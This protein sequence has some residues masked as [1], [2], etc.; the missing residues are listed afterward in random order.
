MAVD[1]EKTPVPEPEL[2]QDFAD[3][4]ELSLPAADE[5]RRRNRILNRL[6]VLLPAILLIG[7]IVGWR[8]MLA[9]PD[10]V[11]IGIDALT[12]I[13]FLLDV[14]LRVDTSL[15]SYLGLQV[16]PS[17]VGALIFALVTVT[18]LGY[19]KAEK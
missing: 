9:S 16:L 12:W 7:P 4:L 13:S 6:G 18:L 1:V 5:I 2:A 15:L 17:I 11:H 10:G 8:L 14:G 3:R 19:R